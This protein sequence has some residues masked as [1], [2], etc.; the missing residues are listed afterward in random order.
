MKKKIE[1][2]VSNHYVSMSDQEYINKISAKY[3]SSSNIEDTE[4]SHMYTYGKSDIYKLWRTEP[5]LYYNLELESVYKVFRK[6][7]PAEY[8]KRDV[9]NNIVKTIHDM[10]SK[11]KQ[12]YTYNVELFNINNLNETIHIGDFILLNKEEFIKTVTSLEGKEWWKNSLNE[13]QVFWRCSFEVSEKYRGLE[14]IEDYIKLFTNA[15]RV[16]YIDN[17]PKMRINFLNTHNP[18]Y[19]KNIIFNSKELQVGS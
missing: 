2:I 18:T 1:N 16:L 13:N 12:V 9:I 7:F 11:D 6:R 8:K 15:V 3:I 19:R 14:I 5:E 10:I 17:F 4:I